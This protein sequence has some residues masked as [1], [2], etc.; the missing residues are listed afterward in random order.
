VTRPARV[1]YARCATSKRD[2]REQ[3]DALFALGCDPILLDEG[4]TGRDRP[5]PQ[6]EGALA[7]C[8]PGDTLV[9]PSLARL[10]KSVPDAVAIFADLHERGLALEVDGHAYRWGD[11]S[12]RAPFMQG[13]AL[14]AEL[15]KAIHRLHTREGVDIA[16]A[17]GKMRGARSKL[18]ADAQRRMRR[19][20]ADGR[21]TITELA[22]RFDVSRSTASRV[23]NAGPEA[24]QPG[25]SKLQ[26]QSTP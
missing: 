12:C 20:Y 10:A 22:E 4:L 1:G 15:G 3:A 14:A 25:A 19:L 18:D 11:D 26:P 6:L 2:R 16:K 21:Y 7:T 8:R 9:V 23:V 24:D 13:L 17:R 5:R